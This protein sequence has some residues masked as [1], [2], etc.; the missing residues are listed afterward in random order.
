MSGDLLPCG[1]SYASRWMIVHLDLRIERGRER[2]KR[3]RPSLQIGVEEPVH[4]IGG[5]GEPATRFEP[6]EHLHDDLAL[7]E[8]L[9]PEAEVVCAPHGDPQATVR[10]Q[11][12]V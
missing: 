8:R 5:D 1:P 3:I 4:A 7:Q 10:R 9:V 6:P 12:V 11:P 2:R